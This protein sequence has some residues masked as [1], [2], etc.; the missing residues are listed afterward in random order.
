MTR[1]GLP[2]RCATVIH[3]TNDSRSGCTNVTS[4]V[5][6][7]LKRIFVGVVPSTF[8][9]TRT[10][11]P[12]G[13]ESNDTSAYSGGSLPGVGLASRAETSSSRRAGDG[14]RATAVGCDVRWL[15]AGLVVRSEA[16]GEVDDGAAWGSVRGEVDRFAVGEPDGAFDAALRAVDGSG[17]ESGFAP[18]FVELNPVAGELD[19]ELDGAAEGEVAPGSLLGA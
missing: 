8:R 5:T 3:R 6:P 13:F 17:V 16:D 2:F 4:N 14:E 18:V 11:A 7:T 12:G 10:A 9:S 1:V 15:R 19:A